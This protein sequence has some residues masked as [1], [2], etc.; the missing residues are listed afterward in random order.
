[1]K[2]VWFLEIRRQNPVK[3]VKNMLTDSKIVTHDVVVVRL[4][5]FILNFALV[6]LVSCGISGLMVSGMC[7]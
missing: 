3:S 1:M 5:D 7:F 4:R 6:E 2:H